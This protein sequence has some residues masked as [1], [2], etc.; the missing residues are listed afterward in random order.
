MTALPISASRNLSG[1]LQGSFDPSATTYHHGDTVTFTN[2]AFGSGS[3][4]KR[5]FTGGAGGIIETP[6]AGATIAETTDWK[7]TV[8][9]HNPVVY[10]DSVR[11]KVMK[12]DYFAQADI[13]ATQSAVFGAPIGYDT[14]IYT[15][16]WIR[17]ILKTTGNVDYPNDTQ[18][19]QFKLTRFNTAYNIVDTVGNVGTEFFF[20]RGWGGIGNNIRIETGDG[21]ITGT[22]TSGAAN[23]VTDTSKS[24]TSGILK[25]RGLQL[26]G[27]TGS[28]QYARITNNT[29]TTL[30]PEFNFSPAPT[31]GTTYEIQEATRYMSSSDIDLNSGWQ[32][33]EIII[34]TNSAGT[35][36][37]TCV[38]RIWKA[39]G[40]HETFNQTDLVFYMGSDRWNYVHFQNYYGNQTVPMT[41]REIYSDDLTVII[42]S[43]SNKRLILCSTPD[44]ASGSTVLEDQNWNTWSGGSVSFPLNV[45]GIQTSGIYYLLCVTGANTVLGAQQIQIGI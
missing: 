10:A 27:G 12:N 25:Y 43:P 13:D 2:A 14:E 42:G 24:F 35:P 23:A 39:D 20:S 4:T 11:G 34:K 7:F 26:T 9:S 19:V 6:A 40:V 18:T 32:R 3:A 15:S 22:A 36:N 31:S 37:G 17:P 28:G 8:A 1:K 38:R 30:T 45:G 44:L 21:F 33:E 16:R 5:M 41:L 29:S